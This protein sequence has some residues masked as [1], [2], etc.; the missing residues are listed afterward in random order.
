ML[1]IDEPELNMHPAWLKVIGSWFQRFTSADQLFVSTH[2]PELLDAFTEGFK[3]GDVAL[4]VF[5]LGEKE[6]RRLDPAELEDFFKKGWEL[7]DLYRVGEP[8][9]G[10]WPW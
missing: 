1:S 2:S 3:S 4:F 10:G 7:G 9:L 5:G 6:M 8:K